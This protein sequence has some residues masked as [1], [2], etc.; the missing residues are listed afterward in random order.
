M[1]NLTCRHV[2]SSISKRPCELLQLK[3]SIAWSLSQF[4][5]RTALVAKMDEI[6]QK[7]LV[8]MSIPYTAFL[9]NR[10]ANQRACKQSPIDTKNTRYVTS[11]LRLKIGCY[12]RFCFKSV[13][14]SLMAFLL[15]SICWM[16]STLLLVEKILN[17]HWIWILKATYHESVQVPVL[18]FSRVCSDNMQT[19]KSIWIQDNIQVSQ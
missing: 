12:L 17:E 15:S 1:Y 11:V 9:L 4:V 3:A 5:S 18:L 8:L 13:S 6:E 10:S 16:D 19:D 14:S 2:Y 7:S